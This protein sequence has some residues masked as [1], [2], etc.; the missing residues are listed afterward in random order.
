MLFV[1]AVGEANLSAVAAGAPCPEQAS[2]AEPA[3]QVNPEHYT[4]WTARSRHVLVC[5]LGYLALVSS[6]TANIHFPLL[7]LLVDRYS[8]SPQAINLTTTLFMAVQGIAPS[9][10]SPL[11][12]SRGRRPVYLCSATLPSKL[13]RGILEHPL[14]RNKLHLG[15]IN[16][17]PQYQT[18]FLPSIFFRFSPS[19]LHFEA[20]LMAK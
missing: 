17:N 11:S 7:E 2:T 15:V 3:S 10:W 4:I 20:L 8:V 19:F 1:M 13:K 12:D 9:T 16:T 18:S 5:L 14:F 6:L